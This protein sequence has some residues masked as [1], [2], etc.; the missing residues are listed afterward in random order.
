MSYTIE[1]PVKNVYTL[2]PLLF[3]IGRLI[4]R[5]LLKLF[6]YVFVM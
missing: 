1:M 4:V 3:F 5:Y 2:F 6:A